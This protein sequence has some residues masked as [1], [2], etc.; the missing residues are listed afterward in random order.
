VSV[1]L[2]YTSS[3]SSVIQCKVTLSNLQ[4]ILINRNNPTTYVMYFTLPVTVIWKP[5]S[6]IE[7]KKKEKTFCHNYEKIKMS[8]CQFLTFYLKIVTVI[9]YFLS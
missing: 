3:T 4:Y 2:L 5:I 1:I 9:I 6:A 7:G 8:Y